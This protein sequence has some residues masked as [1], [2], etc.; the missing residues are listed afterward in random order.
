[1]LLEVVIGLGVFLFVF[2]KYLRPSKQGKFAQECQPVEQKPQNVEPVV[3]RDV[4][5]NKTETPNPPIRM[6]ELEN[7]LKSL[8][9][10]SK[11]AVNC[12]ETPKIYEKYDYQTPQRD[13]KQFEEIISPSVLLEKQEKLL[14]EKNVSKRES[15]PKERLSAYLEKTVLCDDKINSIINNLSLGKLPTKLPLKESPFLND[16]TITPIVQAQSK[17]LE[18]GVHENL[19]RLFAPKENE[20]HTRDYNDNH[21]DKENKVNIIS[22]KEEQKDEPDCKPVEPEKP[23][24]KRFQ[25]NPGFPG[26]LNFGSVIGELKNKTKNGG[27][28]P[29]F[30]KFDIDASENITQENLNSVDEKKKDKAIIED[31]EVSANILADRRTKLETAAQVSCVIL[32]RNSCRER[33]NCGYTVCEFPKVQ[34]LGLETI[35]AKICYSSE[36]NHFI[37]NDF[38]DDESIH[39][40]I[41]CT[42]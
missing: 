12:F 27:L 29:V 9:D 32:L 1:M 36:I 10:E 41:R 17:K 37:C 25:P 15:P 11:E 4:A 5:E 42:F 18:N 7:T 14:N 19:N 6:A 20:I 22:I 3:I 35:L 34:G 8:R 23:I 31:N 26:G 16:L 30:R 28:K 33:G 38:Y 13:N 21:V 2:W 24:L 40:F 39:S